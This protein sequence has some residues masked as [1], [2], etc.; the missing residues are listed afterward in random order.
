MSLSSDPDAALMV[1]F[2]QGDES[3]FDTL[4]EKHKAPIL[5]YIYRQIGNLDEAEDIAQTVFVQV[6]KSAERYEPSAKFT[7]WLFTIARNLCLNEFRRRQRHPVQSIHETGNEDSEFEER[8]FIDASARSP[9]LEIS[10]K[11]L[12]EHILMAIQKLPENQRTAV[13]LCRYEG[14]PY[15]DIAKVLEIS[16]SATKSLLHRA[17]ETLKLEL[18]DFLKET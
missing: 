12:Q 14:L 5:N 9:A 1:R 3:A 15:E 10:E 18:K 7:T 13:L 17:R 8:Q 4:V 2:C 11:E 6:Y 16:V